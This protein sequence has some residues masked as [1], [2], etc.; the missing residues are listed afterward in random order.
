MTRSAQ[1]SKLF[2]PL[3]IR[4]V[5]FRNRVMV[6]PMAQYSA[7][8]GMVTEWHYTHFAKFAM[9]GAGLVC[10]EA[11]KV[12]RRG[13]GTIGDMGLWKDEHIAPI[14]RIADFVRS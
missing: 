6:S 7:V 2:S 10:M 3:T 8:D 4:D 14:R 12:E 11:T 9:G 5:T 1:A 13:L